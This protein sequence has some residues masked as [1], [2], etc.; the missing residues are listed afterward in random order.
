MSNLRPLKIITKN[1]IAARNVGARIDWTPKEI[2]LDMLV[3]IEALQENIN[4]YLEK[5][6]E[7]PAKRARANTK[8]LETLSKAFRVQS[9][10]TA[11]NGKKG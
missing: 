6:M 11:K 8:V 2:A 9:V 4:K 3:V 5:G 7:A 1:V 10:K